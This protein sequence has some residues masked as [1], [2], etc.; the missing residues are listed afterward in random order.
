MGGEVICLCN[1]RAGCGGN[2]LNGVRPKDVI[3][4]NVIA[5][6]T[7]AG[8]EAQHWRQGCQN[9]NVKSSYPLAYVGNWCQDS[10]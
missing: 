3:L 9:N 1:I 7:C 2:K 4:H 8:W 6:H 10:F 5:E